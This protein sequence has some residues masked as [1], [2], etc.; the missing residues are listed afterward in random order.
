MKGIEPGRVCVKLK[1]R[2]AGTKCIITK[3]LDGSFVEVMTATRKKG[4]RKVNIKHLELLD[5]V[6]ELADENAVKKALS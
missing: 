4:T 2:D 1:G 6:V 5:N 3:V